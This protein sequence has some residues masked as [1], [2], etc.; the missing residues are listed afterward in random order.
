MASSKRP[1]APPRSLTSGALEAWLGGRSVATIKAQ[2]HA[3]GTTGQRYA[4]RL[5]RRP[6]SPFNNNLRANDD[7]AKARQ[8]E[9]N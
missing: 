2:K 1:T 6:C 4:G 8:V 7:P 5:Q 9:Q 3:V